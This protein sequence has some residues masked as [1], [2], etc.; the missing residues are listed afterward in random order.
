[1]KVKDAMTGPLTTARSTRISDPQRNSCGLGTADFFLLWDQ[2][3]RSP[4]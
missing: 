4:E 3:A 2:T 1:M